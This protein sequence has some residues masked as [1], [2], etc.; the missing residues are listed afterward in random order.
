LLG[1]EPIVNVQSYL[2]QRAIP[3][4]SLEHAPT[5]TAQM[6]AQAVH[7]TG[8][9]VAKTVLLAVDDDFLVAVLPATHRID[10][11][12]VAQRFAAN[13]VAL[14]DE[15]ECGR[16]FPDCEFG[17]IP[18]FGSKYGL[19]TIVD[20]SLTEDEHI[21]FE[22]NTHAEAIRMRCDDF[23]ALEEPIVIDFARFA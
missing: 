6:L 14:A 18:P 10:L 13:D 9:E 2:S 16:H 20:K 12:R 5:Y 4:D 19:R 8:R 21:V 17:V 3:F 23:L 15:V 7:T 11:D 22:G 1:K